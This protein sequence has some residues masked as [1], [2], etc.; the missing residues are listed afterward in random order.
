[1]NVRRSE[2]RCWEL[3]PVGLAEVCA[4][5]QAGSAGCRRP[6]CRWAARRGTGV[7]IR[8]NVMPY[9]CQAPAR[10]PI[11]GS[12]VCCVTF[13]SSGLTDG[14][15]SRRVVTLCIFNEC[16]CCVRALDSSALHPAC[17]IGKP[18]DQRLGRHIRSHPVKIVLGQAAQ[19][20]P[21][22]RVRVP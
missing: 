12:G 9:I 8:C 22:C 10:P 20:A 4:A 15:A 17:S 14:A 11:N 7:H 5:G 1:M 3:P 2:P 21:L 6:T 19:Q 18:D 16:C 13:L